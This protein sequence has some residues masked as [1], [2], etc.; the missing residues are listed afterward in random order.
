[1]LT[2]SS[3][4]A[5]ERRKRKNGTKGHRGWSPAPLEAT[6]NVLNAFLLPSPPPNNSHPCR[7]SGVLLSLP[8]SCSPPGCL[9]LGLGVTSVPKEQCPG[10]AGCQG[11]AAPGEGVPAPPQ[12]PRLP[13][14][15][16]RGQGAGSVPLD[17]ST[18]QM[19]HGHQGSARLPASALAYRGLNEPHGMPG[20]SAM[21]L[22]ALP[23]A[24][25][26]L[27]CRLR[28]FSLNSVP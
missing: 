14:Q 20:K 13:L 12:P 23:R 7:R 4:V 27:P 15:P 10:W 6:P 28:V 21:G 3:D 1:M 18:R 16:P 19:C 2:S 8:S 11:P 5:A 25:S 17:C 22:P 9:W 26:A 24:A